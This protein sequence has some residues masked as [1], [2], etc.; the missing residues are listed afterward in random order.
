[1]LM[2][3]AKPSR[4]PHLVAKPCR[5]LTVNTRAVKKL[6]E[7]QLLGL[8]TTDSK[9]KPNLPLYVDNNRLLSPK[10]S[11]YQTM[12]ADQ[13]DQ[14][15]FL[16]TQK[17]EQ[18]AG[19]FIPFYHDKSGRTCH[20]VAGRSGSG[21][22]FLAKELCK[23]YSKLGIPSYLISGV[24]AK[25][26]Q[27]Q[28]KHAKCVNID[29]LVELDNAQEMAYRELKIRYKHKKKNLDE[30]QRILFEVKLDKM[31]DDLKKNNFRPTRQYDLMTM[32]PTLFIYDDTENTDDKRVAWLRTQQLIMGRH[33]GIN[34]IVI[35]HLPKNGMAKGARESINEAHVYTLMRPYGRQTS[36]F[37]KT[38]M[39]FDDKMCNVIK[40]LMKTSRYVCVYRDIP[41]LLS[42]QQ[43][44]KY[45]N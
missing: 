13:L 8:F 12:N 4:K 36:S 5:S 45:K 14:M 15:P 39:M 29:D 28:F 11:L 22:S 33:K 31:K 1:M 42:Q 7:R 21:K 17:P 6:D 26:A 43:V 35:N 24:D 30:E 27:S 20:F 41:Y 2:D 19:Q 34:V 9:H 18:M 10:K 38:Y 37:L 25:D 16:I 23:Y 3:Q 44:I 32:K 40:Q